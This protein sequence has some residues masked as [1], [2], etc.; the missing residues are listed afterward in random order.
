MISQSMILLIGDGG[1]VLPLRQI[2]EA[3]AHIWLYRP[4][5]LY[6][7]RVCP[8]LLLLLLIYSNL[9]RALRITTISSP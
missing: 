7:G 5:E 6:P 4:I 8:F 2:A 1:E 9:R 3:Q